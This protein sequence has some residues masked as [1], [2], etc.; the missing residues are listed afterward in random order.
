M[1]RRF[2]DYSFIVGSVMFCR[3]AQRDDQRIKKVMVEGGE[4]LVLRIFWEIRS[5]GQ[6][7]EESRL[8]EATK[9]RM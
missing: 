2:H 1:E 4:R 3:K 7:A 9:G 5:G 6:G 8:V